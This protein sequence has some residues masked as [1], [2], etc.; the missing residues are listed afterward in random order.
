MP[1]TASPGAP[2]GDADLQSDLQS[3]L[4]RSCNKGD[5]RYF[6]DAAGPV[7]T[8]YVVKGSGTI[9][10]DG[11]VSVTLR[12]VDTSDNAI[13]AIITQ[14]GDVEHV[15]ELAEI[16]A[17]DLA[18]EL[19]GSSCDPAPPPRSSCTENGKP[20]PLLRIRFVSDIVWS[21]KTVVPNDNYRSTE[22]LIHDDWSFQAPCGSY[23]N[24]SLDFSLTRRYASGFREH[25]VYYGGSCSLTSQP[26]EGPE[27][28]AYGTGGGRSVVLGITYMPLEVMPV[29]GAPCEE[30][31]GGYGCC[32]L[33]EFSPSDPGTF[34]PKIEPP[35]ITEHWNWGIGKV[36]LHSRTAQVIP[37]SFSVKA[38]YG[39]DKEWNIL[40]TGTIT[41]APTKP[42]RRR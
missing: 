39:G 19:T 36:K 41:V 24:E 21:E 29:T 18:R 27:A 13:V 20:C 7:H 38:V 2:V 11:A 42:P 26:K 32:H 23:C 6:D 31:N 3:M 4:P 33:P 17:A 12:V 9:S 16:A 8:R 40:E 34:T 1:L 15:G 25:D 30:P 5:L 22:G 14:A 35:D 10:D 37:V 28:R